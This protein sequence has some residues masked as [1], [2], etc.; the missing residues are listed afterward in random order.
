MSRDVLTVSSTMRIPLLF[1]GEY[2]QWSERFMNYLEEQTDGKEMI[3]SIK[4]GDQPLL[5]VTQVSIAGATS[6]EQPLLKDK[7]MCYKT[8]K[9]L[10]NALERHMLSFEYGEQDRKAVVLY[11]YETFKATER[12]LLLDT[13]IRYLKVINDLKKYGYS[14]DNCELNFK[15]LNNLQPK[16]KQYATM[17]R[18]NK[19]LLDINID[20]L[21]NILKQNQG[22]VND[23]LKSKKKAVVFNS[24][25]LA[26]VAEQTK[27]FYSK[28]TNNNLKTSSATSLANKK[29]EYV[30]PD[31][32]KE[33]KKIDEKKRDTSKVKCYNF[34]KEGHF[35]KDC[36]KEK[37]KD[38]EY[39]KT[40]M[41]L[42][43]KD[44]DEQVLLVKDHAWMASSSDSDQEI[45]ANMVFMAQM[46]NVMSDSDESSSSKEETIAEVIENGNLWVSVPQTT[47]ENRVS[48][49]KMS[50]PITAKEKINKKND[51]KARSLLL[52]DLPNEHQ[53]TFSVIITQEDLNSKFLRSLPPEWNTHVVV[54]MNKADI[55]TI[56]IDDLYNNFKIVKQDVKKYIGTSTGAQ[57]IAFMTAPSTNSTNAVNTTN[58]ADDAST[59]SP[60][61]NNASPQV[62]T[63]NFS[64][65]AV[66]AFMVE[67]PNGLN[68]LLQDLEQIHEDDLEAMD[69]RGLATVEEQLVTYKKNEVLFSEEVAV[70]KREV[71]CKDYEINMLKSEF[72]KVKQEKEGIEFKIKK[73]DNASKSLDK[74]IGSQITDNSKKGLGYHAV[75][76]PHPLIYNGPIK[77]DL[78]YSGLDE[79]KEPEFKGYGPKDSKLESNINHD[80][81]S[82]DSKET[83]GDSFVK[84]QLSEDTSSFVKSP[85]N[86]DKRTTFSVDKKIEFVKPKH[87]DKPV[88][89]SV[90]YSRH[91][92]ENIAY[93][94]DFKESDG[95]Y[96]TFGR[97]THGGRISSEGT[98]QTNNLDFE[99]V[100]FVNELKFNIFSVSQM[101]DKK[102]YVLFTDTEC[103]VLSLNFK[104]PD[105]SQILL[106][107]P[108]KDNMYSFDM[109]N[110]V[111]KECLT[112]LVE[113]ATL[114]ESLFWYRRL[115]HIN[116]KN[117][118]ELVQD[119]LI[120]GLPIK[121]FKNDQTCVACLKRKQHKASCKFD[122]KS[123]E[124]FFVGY[125]L[126]SKAFR[127]Q[128]QMNLQKDACYFDTPPK[129]VEDG[130]HNEDDDKDKSEDDS[131]PKEVNA[132]GQHVN[133]ASLEVNTG[134]F[135]LNTV[136]PSL[137]T[138]SSSDP[139]S[140]TDMFNL[141]ASDTL[142]ATHVVFFNNKDAPEV[143]LRNI[144]N[145]FGVHTTSHTRIHK[146]HPINIVIGKVQSFVQTR[147]MTKPTFKKG[148]LS[149]VYEEKTYVTL[150]TC[151]YACFLSQIEPTSIA[152]ALSD[153]SWVEAITIEE[154]V[155]VTQP[156]GFKDPKHPDKVY[157]VVKDKYVSD[158]LKK[159]N[160]SDV[161]SASTP[162]DLEKPFVKDGNANDSRMDKRTCYIK[163]KCVKSQPLGNSKEARTL[164]YLSLVVPLKKVGDEAVHKDLGDR[165]ERDATTASSL[166]A[167]PDNGSGHRC[168][169]TIL[170]DVEAQTRRVKSITEAS[171]WRH[172]KLEDYEGIRS[173]PNT[174]IFK[175]LA[176][177]GVDVP[178]FPTMLVQGPLLQSDPTI[179]PPPISSPSRVPTPLY[180]SPLPG[181]NTL[182][183]EEGRMTI[184][185]LT[186][187]CTSLSNKVESLKSNLKQN[188]LTYGAA[189]TKL[190]MKVKK[191]ENK[192]KSRKARR[193]VKLIV[194][195]DEDDFEDPSKQGKKIAQIDKD[196]GITLVQTVTT[197]GAE[198]STAS[199]ED[200]TAKTSDDLDDITLA[201]TLIEIRR[202]ATKP[203]KVKGV[204]FRDMEETPRLV[205]STTTLQPLPYI[206][207]KD[208]EVDKAQKERQKQEEATIAVLTEEFDEIQARMDVD[209]DLATRLT[210]EEQ[211]YQQQVES[212]KKRQREVSDEETSKKQ[213]LEEDNDAKK[214]ELRAILDI[215]PRDDIAINVE[216]LATK[217][218]IVD[219]KT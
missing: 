164:R 54:W 78:S 199:P 53:L 214:E 157:K 130:T 61:V 110:I 155:Y 88:R 149:A 139:H 67:N 69:L 126:S 148:F 37:V 116:F 4:N 158:I 26:L 25:P 19:N 85:L 180:D 219:W 204:D 143:N 5:T 12:E 177:L 29:Q 176:L 131:S 23:A 49:T 170:G 117:I 65:N 194:L 188:K 128:F 198:I 33:E 105:E 84:E 109:K 45:N 159:F 41:L 205:R 120:R 144:L 217:Y 46:E 181:G 79:F 197:A 77:L 34:K 135:E 184:N 20:A 57:N 132:A 97:G 173:L 27:K 208:K 16:W 106:K 163:Q 104:F 24:D 119:N 168:Q 206:N 175:Q 58:P 86:V 138:A 113:S 154:E 165:M 11:E 47:Q 211:E 13:Y 83:S 63:A 14:K 21:Y 123:D 118:I 44:K 161:K 102:K 141:G 92:T 215:V 133:T 36:K 200:K 76:P 190:I 66:Y 8:T 129:D 81:K 169:E 156:P 87:H 162:V 62:S 122:G 70:L 187:L 147:R 38:Y 111:P 93:L 95:G 193:R 74:L 89:R 28:P 136:D 6:S 209:H 15:F 2:S 30:K 171:I 153:S 112:C 189:Y 191:L 72:E 56:S 35:A 195:E 186:V 145:S 151:L 121:C 18:Q 68:L 91:M 114:D 216:S 40:K 125:S 1:R 203:Q 99:N 75:P 101:C 202:S 172:L 100:Y 73:F 9:D 55:E 160:Y 115:G 137:N 80:K 213:N 166:E 174:K 3:N 179:S 39:Y 140:P 127:V 52:M 42:A 31:D 150:D 207:L 201:E 178:L 48:V 82:D 64:D 124:G 60:N 142:K 32:K 7:S 210:Y 192:V 51:V 218:L 96:V 94:S 152:K 196:E 146:D 167:Q 107:L 10:W 182:G 183:S 59:I 71:A 43:K 108:R 22:D 212:S 17:M 134:R 185:E 50:V 90:R 98:L 103:L